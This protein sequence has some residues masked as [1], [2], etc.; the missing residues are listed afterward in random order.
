MNKFKTCKHNLSSPKKN[1]TLFHVDFYFS[2]FWFLQNQ[3]DA[4]KVF[5]IHSIKRASKKME[6]KYSWDD[7]IPFK[8]FLV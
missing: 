2:L 4:I 7:G 6:I 3:P 8:E 1:T 5:H